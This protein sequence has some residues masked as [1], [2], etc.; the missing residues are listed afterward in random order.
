M[1]A[2]RLTIRNRSSYPTIA[3]ERAVQFATAELEIRR[4]SVVV[5]VDDLS[6][7]RTC[8]KLWTFD[9]RCFEPDPAIQQLVPKRCQYVAWIRIGPSWVFA[10]ETVQDGHSREEYKTWQEWLVESVAYSAKLV[11]DWHDGVADSSTRSGVYA[12]FVLERYRDEAPEATSGIVGCPHCGSGLLRDVDVQT[13]TWF[14]AVA[15]DGDALRVGGG[16]EWI[17]DRGDVDELA[18]C[19][20]CGAACEAD[21]LLPVTAAEEAQAQ[22]ELGRLIESVDND[23]EVPVDRPAQCPHCGSTRLVVEVRR[24]STMGSIY[25]RDDEGYTQVSDR[26]PAE[27][28]AVE[29]EVL[30]CGSCLTPLTAEDLVPG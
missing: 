26:F 6:R 17:K 8:G 13:D 22:A 3:V 12:R 18:E 2:G 10:A 14:A 27:S 20:R 24:A 23:W 16:A 21:D 5:I 25:E 29:A 1:R 15:I 4:E 9:T 28:W 7:S 30:E 11:Q 19:Y